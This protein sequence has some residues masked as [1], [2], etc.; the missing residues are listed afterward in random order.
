MPISDACI[1]F[2]ISILGLAYPVSL[3]AI[4]RLDE[5]YKSILIVQRF[6]RSREFL[7][8]QGMLIAAIVTV[9]VQVVWIINWKPVPPEKMLFYYHDWAE[10]LLAIVTAFLI[11]AFF[12]FTRRIIQF[13][14]PSSL[15]SG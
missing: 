11:I 13:Y 5:K 9:A 1:Y 8:F 3:P 12:L 6:R 14:I 2:I 7:F 4:T 10:I 15:V